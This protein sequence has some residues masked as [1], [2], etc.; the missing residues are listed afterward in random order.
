MLRI[1]A[2]TVKSHVRNIRKKMKSPNTISAMVR[3]TQMRSA[4]SQRLLEGEVSAESSVLVL[5]SFP[6]FSS[7][8]PHL[9]PS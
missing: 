1:G 5:A 9:S 8:T 4:L 3:Y 7:H 2:E 6:D